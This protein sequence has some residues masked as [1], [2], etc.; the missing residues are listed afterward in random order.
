MPVILDVGGRDAPLST[1]ILPR[2]TILSPNETEL[3]RISG[4][5]VSNELEA[6]MAA[7]SLLNLG[8]EQVLVKLGSKGS[9]L[10]TGKGHYFSR[11]VLLQACTEGEVIRQPAV[12]VAKVVD[13]TGG[14]MRQ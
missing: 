11:L 8:V 14:C 2:L 4:K 10:V 7:R 3:V 13:T 1:S 6:E 12:P 5:I 9:M